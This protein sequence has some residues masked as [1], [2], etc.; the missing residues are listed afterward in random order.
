MCEFNVE[1]NGL[2][3]RVDVRQADSQRVCTQLLRATRASPHDD[4]LRAA[5]PLFQGTRDA[6]LE[7]RGLASGATAIPHPSV[8][9]VDMNDARHIRW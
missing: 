9:V 8:A 5:A 2:R 7:T 1:R 4:R 6:E 3:G